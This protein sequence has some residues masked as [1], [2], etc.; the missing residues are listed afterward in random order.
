VDEDGTTSQNTPV[1]YVQAN[2]NG[3]VTN[4]A[5]TIRIRQTG[6]ETQ[7]WVTIL[8]TGQTRNLANANF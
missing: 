8:T 6:Q 7:P 4:T 2:C 3:T 5:S 1:M